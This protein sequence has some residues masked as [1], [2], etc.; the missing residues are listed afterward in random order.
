MA[1]EY[2]PTPT[3]VFVHTYV[4]LYGLT[5]EAQDK[6]MQIKARF[7]VEKRNKQ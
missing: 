7:F 5:I 2:L 3:T 1:I 4:V 6:F